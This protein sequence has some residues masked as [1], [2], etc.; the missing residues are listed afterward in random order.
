M[1]KRS[2]KLPSLEE[3]LTE[4]SQLIDKMEHGEL[5]LE[6]SLTHFER[7][8]ALVKHCQKILTEA[9]Q[10]VKILIQNNHQEELSVYEEN[11]NESPERNEHDD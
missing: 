1:T 8:I 9:E 4:V 3:S 6:Q 7:G 11:Q 2:N 10:K 5:T